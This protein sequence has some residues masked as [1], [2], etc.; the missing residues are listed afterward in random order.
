MANY[1]EGWAS[2]RQQYE[3]NSGESFL[4]LLI[5]AQW[6]VFC[7]PFFFVSAA[8]VFVRERGV[9]GFYENPVP[10]GEVE[11]LN[12]YTTHRNNALYKLETAVRVNMLWDAGVRTLMQPHMRT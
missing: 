5:V 8:C 2:I 4:H 1:E 9:L 6:F 11:L 3:P 12:V 7:L 10:N